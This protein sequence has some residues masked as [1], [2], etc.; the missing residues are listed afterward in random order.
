[1]RIV[2]LRFGKWNDEWGIWQVLSVEFEI[3]PKVYTLEEFEG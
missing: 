3:E 1:M 2:E